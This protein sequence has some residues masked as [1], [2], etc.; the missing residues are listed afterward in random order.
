VCWTKGYYW[1][2]G[3]DMGSK[4]R[5][6]FGEGTSYPAIMTKILQK[7]IHY[8]IGKYHANYGQFIRCQTD[9]STLCRATAFQFADTI[10]S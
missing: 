9:S 1:D 6:Y 4:W 3:H 5:I 8:A 7:L 10:H 2:V